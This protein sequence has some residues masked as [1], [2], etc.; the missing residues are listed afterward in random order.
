M[1]VTHEH[2]DIWKEF[3]YRPGLSRVLATEIDLEKLPVTSE[4]ELFVK[5]LILH[6]GS[7]YHALNEGL[8]VNPAGLREDIRRFFSL[9]IPRAVW[10]RIRVLQDAEF[11]KFVEECLAEN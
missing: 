3:Y 6:L 7:G 4:E 11:V 1:T 5:L 2:R 10:E 9:P 8:I